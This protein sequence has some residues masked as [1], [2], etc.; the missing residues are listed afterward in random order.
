MSP[1]TIHRRHRLGAYICKIV[2]ITDKPSGNRFINT[3]NYLTIDRFSD[4]RF[5]LNYNYG[6]LSIK[7]SFLLEYI[8]LHNTE[9]IQGMVADIIEY[10]G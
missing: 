7:E 3:A 4:S 2:Q 5:N 8:L 6:N 9:G 1:S 10:R